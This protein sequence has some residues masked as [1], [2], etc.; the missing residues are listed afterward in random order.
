MLVGL[1]T[2]MAACGG[3][4]KNS[5]EEPETFG[6]AIG[7]AMAPKI[8][9]ESVVATQY[10]EFEPNTSLDNANIVTLPI[11]S[12]NSPAGV[13]ISGRVQCA[14]NFAD[15]YLFTPRRSGSYSVFLCADTCAEVVQVHEY[16]TGQENHDYR[17]IITG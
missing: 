3:D 8:L 7:C 5:C 9:G 12:A 15:Y 4:K 1:L 11:A 6:K 13:E 2:T 16:N 10:D 17:L 14:D